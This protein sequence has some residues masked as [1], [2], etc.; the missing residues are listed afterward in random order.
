MRT[1]FLPG[2]VLSLALLAGC[3]SGPRVPEAA[4]MTPTAIMDHHSHARPEEARIK[5]LELDL[6]VDMDRHIIE[7]SATYDVEGPGQRVV[8]DTDGLI[9]RAVRDEQGKPLAFELGDSTFLG[10]A[11]TVSFPKQAERFSVDYTTTDRS[12]ALQWLAPRQTAG[13]QHPFLFTQGQAILTRTW[14]PVQDSPGIRFTY[15]ARVQVP[16]QLMA[17]MSATNPTERSADGVYNFTMDKAVPA[18]LIALAVGDIDF[19][20]IGERT[21]VYAERNMVSKAAWEFADMERMLTEAEKLYGP[22]RWGR[23]DLIVL[24]PS[25]PFGGMENPCL[26]FATPTIIAGD[27]SLTALVAHELAHSWSG[28][29]VTNA[30]WDDFWLNEGFTVYF[31]QRICEAVYGKD[32]K[33][34]LAVL[35][36][37]DLSRT[38][39]EMERDGQSADTHLR[40][41]LE[42]RNPDDGMTD[43]AYEKG[44]ALLR[45]LEAK[46]GRPVFDAFLRKYFDEHAFQSMT[47]D[48]FIAYVKEN[49]LRPNNLE[50]D[51]TAWIDAPGLPGDAIVPESDHFAKVEAELARWRSGTPA[52]QLAT[53]G[54]TTFEWLHFLRHLPPG[55][56]EARMTEL[57]A[58]FHFTATG[59][60]EVLAAWL[61]QC[62][63]AD[64]DAAQARLDSFLNTVGRRKF[65]EPLYAELIKTEKGRLLAQTIYRSARPNY[66]AVSVRTLDAMLAWKDNKPPANF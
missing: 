63:K 4:D 43:I 30:T 52:T 58:A 39:E 59:N 34:M 42:G 18:Y 28:N 53:N 40:L 6:R 48:G 45:T 62:I 65:L 49:L 33:E 38:L 9:I 36:A 57:D 16:S 44:C 8:L 5:H 24:P 12:D 20:P 2:T 54:W 31:E 66:H 46:V 14:I 51:L 47:T 11:L 50:F 35:G 10:R 19:E 17:V 41:H 3:S 61:D 15:S 23:Y 60:S 22:Y 56:D 27:R 13:G 26:T 37:Q 55:T 64:H 32:Y 25:F 21:G 7:G 29:L 1:F